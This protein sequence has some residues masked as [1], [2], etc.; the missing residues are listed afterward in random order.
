LKKGAQP[1]E[2]ERRRALWTAV[3]G[4]R[5]I[6]S[7]TKTDVER[8]VKDRRAGCIRLPDHALKTSVS[9]TTV[10]A[11]IIFLQTVLNWAVEQGKLDRSPLRGYRPPKT[12]RP[13]RPIANYDRYLKVAAVAAQ[14]HPRFGSF[15]ALVESLGW[16]VSA[17]CQLRAEDIDRKALPEAPHGRI[18]KYGVIDKERVEMWLPLLE[19]ERRMLDRLPVL[20]GYLF[21]SLHD[22]DKPWRRSYARDLLERAEKLAGLEPIEGGDFHPYRRKWYT[23]R[24]H[25][26][27]QDVMAAAG[28][29][30]PRTVQLL[31]QQVDD[32]TLYAVRAEPRKLREPALTGSVTG[33]MK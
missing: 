19:T 10:G 32:A 16:R 13:K 20:R 9:E 11:D 29:K 22:P 14:V 31:Y 23:E 21:P 33:S 27:L 30:D 6:A 5:E 15:M 25:L 8:F 3:L 28:A 17:I 4:D 18:R 12:A 2:D 26:P 1:E 7:L 24:K